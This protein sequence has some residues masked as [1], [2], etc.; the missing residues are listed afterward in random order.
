MKKTIYG[1]MLL[2]LMS[3][4][5]ILRVE[6]ISDEIVNILAPSNNAIL[7]TTDVTFNWQEIDEADEYHIQIANPNFTEAVQIV[8]DSIVAST[9]FSKTLG[10]GNYEWR[11]KAMNSAYETDY[12]LQSFSI[13]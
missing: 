8:T 7:N 3:C 12:T 9:N 6:D 4:S 11:V 2:T 13:E 1:F 10:L 5:D